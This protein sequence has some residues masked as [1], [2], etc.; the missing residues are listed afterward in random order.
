MPGTR[1]AIYAHR[2]AAAELGQVISGI[3]RHE[4]FP[5]PLDQVPAEF[6]FNEVAPGRTFEI[7]DL[8]LRPVALN[9]PFGS[10]GYRIDGDGTS[11]AYVSDTAP[12]SEMLHKQHFVAGPESPSA[13]DRLA[14]EQMRADLVDTLAGVDTVIYDTHFLPEE[15]ARFPHWGHSTPDHALELLRGLRVRRL[16]LFH[17]APAHTDRMMDEIAETYR[18]RGVADGVQVVVAREAMSLTIGVRTDPGVGP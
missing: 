9:H 18:E 3:T 14:L 6:E 15:Y 16:V 17:H 7:G 10:T 12:F 2:A 5:V 13:D 11:I 1:I 8:E 4:F